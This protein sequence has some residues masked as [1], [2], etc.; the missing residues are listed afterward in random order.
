M[1]FV[2]AGVKM[3]HVFA[4][5][6]HKVCTNGD[7][8]HIHQVDLD[9]EFHKFQINNNFSFSDYTF[10]FFIEKETPIELVSQYSFISEFQRL[11]ASLRGPPVLI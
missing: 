6:H 10:T 11:Q 9:C 7:N 8:L 2:P 3:A 4:H 5:H 1:L